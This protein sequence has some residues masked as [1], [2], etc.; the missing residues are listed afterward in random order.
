MQ[1]ANKAKAV[2]NIPNQDLAQAVTPSAVSSAFSLASSAV[3]FALPFTSLALP[4]ASSAASCAMPFTSLAASL[5]CLLAEAHDSS[6]AC[7]L[8]LASGWL[9][10]LAGRG[11]VR[12][13]CSTSS[14]FEGIGSLPYK[15][16]GLGTVLERPKRVALSTSS[17]I[18]SV[19]S[20]AVSSASERKSCA[21]SSNSITSGCHNDCH[22]A[23]NKAN[24]LMSSVTQAAAEFEI[25]LP[26]R[27]AKQQRRQSQCCAKKDCTIS[28]LSCFANSQTIART[29]LVL[30]S[31]PRSV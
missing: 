18:A 26:E 24:F 12:R 25:N 19:A 1:H 30:E 27:K 9:E 5:V 10:P 31:Y 3:S 6:A 17:L 8:S 14:V 11:C 2:I 20:S 28:K 7:L 15:P 22:K 4:F 13:H 23:V 29:V 21:Y 16:L